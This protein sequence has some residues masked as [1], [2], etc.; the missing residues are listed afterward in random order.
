MGI[1]GGPSRAWRGFRTFRGTILWWLLWHRQRWWVISS[2]LLSFLSSGIVIIVAQTTAAIYDKAIEEQSRPLGPLVASLVFFAV[3]EFVVVWANLQVASRIEYQIEYDLRNR[4]YH[5]LQRAAPRDLD[6]VATGQMVT[7]SL[8]DLELLQLLLQLI[9]FIVSGVPIILGFTIYL[10]FINVPLTLLT[11]S[12]FA[13]NG[14]LVNRMRPRLWGSPSS[15]STS[16]PR[17]RPPSTSPS[18]ASAS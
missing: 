1:L 3:F 14:Y 7:R 9:P 6:S 8:S 17:S 5:Q 13:V 16:G 10:S 12:L 11:L 15:G 4:L 2:L 18:A